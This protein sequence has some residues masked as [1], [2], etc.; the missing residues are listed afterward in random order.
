MKTLATISAQ[1]GKN[2]PNIF[3]ASRDGAFVHFYSTQKRGV[4]KV[5]RENLVLQSPHNLFCS[6]LFSDKRNFSSLH[7]CEALVPMESYI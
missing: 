7:V 5:N 1:L 4:K 3:A 2:K 6:C